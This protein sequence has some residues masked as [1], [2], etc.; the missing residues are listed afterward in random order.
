M[1]L[2]LVVGLVSLFLI[3]AE[4][5]LAIIVYRLL[6]ERNVWKEAR[7]RM[8]YANEYEKVLKELEEPITI[9]TSRYV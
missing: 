9:R 2:L 7:N 3:V 8:K 6:Y 1:S 4:I 5:R